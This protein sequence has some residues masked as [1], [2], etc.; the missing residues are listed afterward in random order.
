MSK[1]NDT[2]RID[3]ESGFIKCGAIRSPDSDRSPVCELPRGHDGEHFGRSY[4][5]RWFDWKASSPSRKDAA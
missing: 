3:D 1:P 4:S 2:L 5:G